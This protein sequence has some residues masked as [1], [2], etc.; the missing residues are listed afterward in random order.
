MSAAPRWSARRPTPAGRGSDTLAGVPLPVLDLA[1]APADMGAIHGHHARHALRAFAEE[2]IRLAGEPAWSGR[3]L[4]RDVVLWL[5]QRCLDDH[6]AYAPDL[7]RELEA[8]A[9]AAGLTPAEALVVNGFTDFVDTVYAVGAPMPPQPTATPLAAMDCTAFLVPGARAAGGHAMFGQ[10]WD[11]H[12]TA[13]EHVAVLR[14]APRDAP[15]FVA[16]TVLGCVGMIG[17]NEHGVCVGINN[18]SAGDGEVGVTWPFVVRKALQQRDLEG[19]LRCITEARLA[20]AHNYQLLDRH[21]RGA[22]VEATTTRTV[23]TPLDGRALVHT[24]HCLAAATREVERPIEDEALESSFARYA[25]ACEL[26]ERDGLTPADLEA[27]TR[28]GDA[29]CYRSEDLDVATCGAVVMRPGTGEFWAVRGLPSE[30]SFARVDLP[31]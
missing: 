7:A 12:A 8:L 16:F 11:M 23:V 6:R 1:G 13:T 17:M 24:N 19:A 10:T 14:A 20:G 5:A 3:D 25:R 2:R 9:E 29:I 21:G 30:G 28:D 31:R 15:A 22:N 26:L 27:V 4:P 18:L